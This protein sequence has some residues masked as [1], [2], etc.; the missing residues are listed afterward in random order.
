[1]AVVS[2]ELCCRGVQALEE[3]KLDLQTGFLV[4]QDML[5]HWPKI[6]S[7]NGSTGQQQEYQ[8]V[9]GTVSSWSLILWFDL[10]YLLFI[11]FL[12]KLL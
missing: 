12:Y 1:M 5:T 7:Y 6:V 10:K 4:V 2:F 8:L 9:H 11:L 3:W